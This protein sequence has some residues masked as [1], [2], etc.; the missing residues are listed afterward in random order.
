MYLFLPIS[1]IPAVADGSV[2][3]VATGEAA[4][5]RPATGDIPVP[6]RLVNIVFLPAE[7][8]VSQTSS[9]ELGVIQFLIDPAT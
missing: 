8:A 1:K 2:P 5:Y 3:P 4:S 9:V 6:V 7:L